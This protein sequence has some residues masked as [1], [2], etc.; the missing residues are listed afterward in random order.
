M[1]TALLIEI[2][3]IVGGLAIVLFAGKRLWSAYRKPRDSVPTDGE[4]AESKS[5]R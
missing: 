2:L 3:Q 4:T 1:K 5:R